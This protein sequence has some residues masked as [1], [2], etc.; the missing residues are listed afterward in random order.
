MRL[1]VGQQIGHYT[2]DYRLGAGGM[3]E[4]WAATNGILRVQVALKVLFS[5]NPI[6]QQ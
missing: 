6:L 4:V 1:S 5:G 3:A 2:L